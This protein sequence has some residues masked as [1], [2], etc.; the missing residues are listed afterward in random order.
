MTY[1]AVSG[2]T[3]QSLESIHRA[4]RGSL[5]GIRTF[6]IILQGLDADAK[7]CGLE[8]GA[9]AGAVKS[10]FGD[11][12]ARLVGDE[13]QLY[14]VFIDIAALDA[15]DRCTSMV[16]LRVSAFV[17]PAYPT[18]IAAEITPWIQRAFL[19]SPKEGHAHI[20]TG[21]LMKQASEFAKVWREQQP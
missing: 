10:G 13:I 8:D 9:L 12:P 4:W 7:N 19:V 5:K 21:E 1:I 6:G 15:G 11:T 16:S 2:A 3:E 18:L 14:N 20:I 17:D